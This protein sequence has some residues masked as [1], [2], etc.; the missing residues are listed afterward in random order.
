M[1]A[2]EVEEAAASAW[3]NTRRGA[4][5]VHGW[6]PEAARGSNGPELRL[7][8]DGGYRVLG[9][10][11]VYSTYTFEGAAP[12]TGARHLRIEVLPQGGPGRG[13]KRTFLLQEVRVLTRATEGLDAEWQ[14]IRLR[15]ARASA[16]W[17]VGGP[18]APETR[19]I[20]RRG[21]RCD[22][23]P[24]GPSRRTGASPRSS[25]SHSMRTWS[26]ERRLR[27]ELVQE[28]RGTG[29]WDRSASGSRRGWI[30]THVGPGE[31]ARGLAGTGLQTRLRPECHDTR[32]GG[33]HDSPCDQAVDRGSFLEPREV[34]TPH[35]P[36]RW[37]AGSDPPRDRLGLARW[38]AAPENA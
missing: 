27:L 15:S 24:A 23:G 34:I 26:P 25:S 4:G 14:P 31:L 6:Q 13:R 19:G 36:Q 1:V 11:A 21:D 35:V 33:A 20:R 22:P 12:E 28:G 10:N 29:R 30:R 17:T 38:I 18:P 7:E 9:Q 37:I 5:A 2:Y 16:A 3:P 32:A 8:E